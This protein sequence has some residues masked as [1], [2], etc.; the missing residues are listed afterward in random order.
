MQ[1]R[2]AAPER[3]SHCAF[4][5]VSQKT[6]PHPP[7]PTQNQPSPCPFP[8]ILHTPSV[9]PET[10]HFSPKTPKN[11]P[12]HN[13]H[14][15]FFS[16][17]PNFHSESIISYHHPGAPHPQIV[18]TQMHLPHKNTKTQTLFQSQR[19]GCRGGARRLS[20]PRTALSQAKKLERNFHL[21]KKHLTSV[22]Q[23][24]IHSP[25]TPPQKIT[26][27]TTSTNYFFQYFPISTPNQSFSSS[28]PPQKQFSHKKI[29]DKEHISMFPAGVNATTY[30]HTKNNFLQN[31]V[32]YRSIQST[33]QPLQNRLLRNLYNLRNLLHIHPY[34]RQG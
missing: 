27:P 30:N 7:K 16:T 17:F 29:P 14:Q 32:P 24:T 12:S 5:S 21:I 28:P 3:P 31:P 11:Q 19:R 18:P 25:P 23:E 13:I 8:S 1:G 34:L 6:L 4:T 20:A 2:G 10:L 9:S 33:L 22:S 15:Q 26:L